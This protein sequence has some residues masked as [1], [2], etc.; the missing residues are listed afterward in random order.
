MAAIEEENRHLK[1]RLQIVEKAR[2]E[3]L[4]TLNGD[5][6]IQALV[7]E[8]KMLEQHLEEAHLQL[9]DIKSSWSGQNLALETQVSRLSKQ[10]AEETTEKRKILKAKDDLNE[11][12]K[13]TEFELLKAQEEIKQRDDKVRIYTSILHATLRL[14]TS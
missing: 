14:N 5:D 10:V 8:R 6:K 4:S 2:I 12:I 1:M 9:S 11:R 13:H 7:Q 3:A